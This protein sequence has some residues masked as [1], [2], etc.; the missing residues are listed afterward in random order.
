M[1]LFTKLEEELKIDTT[2]ESIN[3]ILRN[4]V[5]SDFRYSLDLKKIKTIKVM[6]QDV[7]LNKE[8]L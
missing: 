4:T 7:I 1:A 8:R 2:N 6:R 5:N 3:I